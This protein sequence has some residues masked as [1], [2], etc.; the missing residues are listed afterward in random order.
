MHVSFVSKQHQ[1]TVRSYRHAYIY[2]HN[3]CLDD[4]VSANDDGA[5]VCV[6]DVEGIVNITLVNVLGTIP[7]ANNAL[8]VPVARRVKSP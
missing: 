8:C 1:H 2:H 5:F 6:V 3:S 7:L 4:S